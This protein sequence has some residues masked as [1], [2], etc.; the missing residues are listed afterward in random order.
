MKSKPN[1]TLDFGDFDDQEELS[2]EE[3]AAYDEM[4]SYFDQSLEQFKE[5]KLSTEPLWKC[6]RIP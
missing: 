1:V 4:E 2:E 5:G 3:K 6:P